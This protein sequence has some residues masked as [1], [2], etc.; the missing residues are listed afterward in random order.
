MKKVYNYE[1]GPHKISKQIK[2]ENIPDDMKEIL[3]N[4]Y[5]EEIE[6][7]FNNL[8]P[9]YDENIKKQLDKLKNNVFYLETELKRNISLFKY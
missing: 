7:I 8:Y 3:K 6:K 9:N 4:Y 1:N 5:E 2:N